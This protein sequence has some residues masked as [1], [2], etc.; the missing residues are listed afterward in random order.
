MNGIRTTVCSSVAE[1]ERAAKN[2]EFSVVVMDDR[3]PDGNGS[4]L[5][6]RLRQAGL[7]C[8]LIMATAFPDVAR[9]VSLMRGGLFDYLPKPFNPDALVDC[10]N[11]ALRHSMAC[12]DERRVTYS[13]NSHA[14]RKVRELV[15]QAA[16]TPTVTVLLT[17]E[18]GTGKELAARLIHEATFATDVAP[19]VALDCSAVP[20]ELFESELFGAERGAYTG[21]NQ[22]RM[23]LVEAAQRGTLFLDEIG[24]MP[25]ALQAKLLRFLET[26]EF[27]RIG[28]TAIQQFHG[29][30]IAATNRDLH[31][32]AE[33]GMFRKDLLYRLDV[34]SIPLPSLRER[35]EDI[36]AIAEELLAAIAAKHGR[37]VPFLGDSDLRA[38]AEYHFPGNVRELRNLLERGLIR[39]PNGEH[40]LH[41]E[42]PGCVVP[43]KS[44]GERPQSFTATSTLEE[45]E[46][47]TL[48]RALIQENWNISSTARRLGTSRQSILRRLEK[49]PSLKKQN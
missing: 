36:P 23:G 2:E 24:E 21:A 47:E 40:W 43:E 30:V 19:L 48:R 44:I 3:L 37:A 9:A 5:I 26:R 27:R 11:R 13:G 8:P 32:Y 25:L 28:S 20:A 6:E 35:R 42:I 4:L 45:T 31:E 22:A 1:A 12:Q 15:S 34:F 18:T 33:K 14:A 46:R 29:R 17:G 39:T 41:L 16:A 10:I 7:D 38:L 49:W